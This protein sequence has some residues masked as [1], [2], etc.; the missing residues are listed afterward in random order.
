MSKHNCFLSSIT[1]LFGKIKVQGTAETNILKLFL[2]LQ[3]CIIFIFECY[4]LFYFIAGIEKNH[5]LL[6]QTSS[7]IVIS[8]HKPF[9][10]LDLLNFLKEADLFQILTCLT[11]LVL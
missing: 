5:Q 8:L 2:G 9:K 1:I 6:S 4:L 3:K 10:N 11:M 7:I